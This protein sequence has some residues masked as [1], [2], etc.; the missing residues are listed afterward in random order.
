MDILRNIEG[1]YAFFVR[2]GPTV[3]SLGDLPSVII[4]MNTEQFSHHVNNDKNDFVTWIDE[5]IGDAKLAKSLKRVK[6]KE[7]MVRK[8]NAYLEKFGN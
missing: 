6:R 4:E 2:D 1:N 5:V 8:L 3:N 7:T